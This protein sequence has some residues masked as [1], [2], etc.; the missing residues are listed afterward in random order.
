MAERAMPSHLYPPR[1]ALETAFRTVRHAQIPQVPDVVLALRTELAREEPDLMRAADLIAQDLAMTAQVLKTIN[2]PLMATRGQVTSI[3][4]AVSLIGIK[5]LANLVTAEA[6]KRLLEERRGGARLVMDFIREQAQ[7]AMAVASLAGDV[8]PEE[9]YLFGLLQS[10][11][12][13]IFSDLSRD[14]ANEWAIH[15]LVAPQ[16]LV[17]CEQRLFKADHCAVGFLLAGV[18]HLSEPVAL[19]VY[20]QHLFRL[21]PPCDARMCSL[22][23]IAQLE[24]LLM[25][26]RRGIED[27]PEL[28]DRRDW[29]LSELNASPATW[30]ELS[31]R[32]LSSP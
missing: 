15:A 27:A 32:L 1:S 19:A 30:E 22:L 6:F 8:E 18:W 16:R 10:A 26:L 20:H 24:R 9:A 31:K 12:C 21:P 29:A 5:R 25:A 13:L 11:G 28:L 23:A 4:Q 17:E 14:Y 7:T 3:R 2:S